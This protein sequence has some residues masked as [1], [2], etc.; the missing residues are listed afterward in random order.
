M[1]IL[2]F[3]GFETGT[4][5]ELLN[6]YGSPKIRSREES[7]ETHSGLNALVVSSRVGVGYGGISIGEIAGGYQIE[8]DRNRIFVRFYCFFKK[9]PTIST[10]FFAVKDLNG[11]IKMSLRVDNAG[12][13]IVKGYSE[14]SSEAADTFVAYPDIFSEEKWYR[15]ELSIVSNGATEIKI[16]G[17]SLGLISLIS[18]NINIAYIMLGNADDELSPDADYEFTIDDVKITN[19]QFPGAGNII[20]LKPIAF[21]YHQ[22]WQGFLE[23]IL[24]VDSQYLTAVDGRKQ[25]FVFYIKDETYLG[26]IASIKPTAF[27]ISPSDEISRVKN[28]I[29][30]N[31]EDTLESVF[32]DIPSDSYYPIANIYPDNNGSAWTRTDLKK[33]EYGIVTSDDTT[34]IN[35]DYIALQVDYS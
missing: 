3:T 35:C 5:N 32:V 6:I 22:Q 17:T 9:I 34:M 1:A 23:D 30:I 7:Y 18:N 28:L 33:M 15:V 12:T 19:D 20:L 4:I 11:F 31:D 2:N 26:T 24:D 27:C 13:L 8:M 21:G 14:T 10:E 25:T 16:N 29:R